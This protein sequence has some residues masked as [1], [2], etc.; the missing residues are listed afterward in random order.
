MTDNMIES[1]DP[2]VFE[3]LIL[4]GARTLSDTDRLLR[5]LQRWACVDVYSSSYLKE[6]FCYPNRLQKASEAGADEYV[7]NQAVRYIIDSCYDN[8]NM[9]NEETLEV[10]TNVGANYVIPKDYPGK[11]LKTLDSIQEFLEEW[12]KRKAADDI[13]VGGMKMMVPLQPDTNGS[14]LRHYAEYQDF[15][16]QFECYALGGLQQFKN[17][18]RQ[19]EAIQ[20][21]ADRV[22]GKGKHIHLFGVGTSP[23]LIHAIRENPF[24]ADSLDCSTMEFMLTKNRLADKFWTQKEFK[25]PAGD[26]NTRLR[27]FYAQA[28]LAQLNYML[29]PFFDDPEF[30]ALFEDKSQW[31]LED[32]DTPFGDNDQSKATIDIPYTEDKQVALTTFENSHEQSEG[33]PSPD[34]DDTPPEAVRSND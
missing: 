25:L 19:V 33:E 34:A 11:P 3:G 27:A 6:D 23:R 17:T 22:D 32:F 29:S 16:D 31:E 14:Y 20:R 13:G 28:L 9:S 12:N 24:M 10:A 5:E 15:Y 26:G 2:N 30:D 8:E 7:E 21:F 1:L 18:R 4:S